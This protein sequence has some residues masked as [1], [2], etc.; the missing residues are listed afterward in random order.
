MFDL[1]DFAD[2]VGQLDHLRVGVAAGEDQMHEG[3]LAAEDVQHLL[4]IDQLELEGI[5][6]LVED[7]EVVRAGGDFLADQVDGVLGIGPVLDPRVGVPPDAT[8]PL[9]RWRAVRWCSSFA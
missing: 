4:Q 6:D 2:R 7:Q 1:A 3:G 9:N 8:E 5:V